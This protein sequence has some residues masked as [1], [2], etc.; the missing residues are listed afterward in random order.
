MPHET[1]KNTHRTLSRARSHRSRAR[2]C[3]ECRRP[4]P[5]THARPHTHI[6]TKYSAGGNAAS[7]VRFARFWRA[8]PPDDWY[9]QNEMLVPTKY[10]H[11]YCTEAHNTYRP[12]WSQ[13]ICLPAPPFGSHHKDGSPPSSAERTRLFPGGTQ[14]QRNER[15]DRTSV[16][17]QHSTHMLFLW[18]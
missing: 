8:T 14:F 15:C 12:T 3:W 11:T 18:N 6:L 10:E 4:A 13:H 1:Q 2:A 5:I 17:P 9:R 16:R 7:R